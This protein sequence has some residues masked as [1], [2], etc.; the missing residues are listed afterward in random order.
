MRAVCWALGPLVAISLTGTA[1]AGAAEPVK[2]ADDDLQKQIVELKGENARLGVELRAARLEITVLRST[3]PESKLSHA[4]NLPSGSTSLLSLEDANTGQDKLDKLLTW[5]QNIWNDAPEYYD[6]KGW[7]LHKVQEREDS[8]RALRNAYIE[9]QAPYNDINTV[10]TSRGPGSIP[11]DFM[12]N[13]ALD[14]RIES[15]VDLD[16]NYVGACG[17]TAAMADL[18]AT[19]PHS[20]SESPTSGTGASYGARAIAPG[21]PTT[22]QD[23]LE[24]LP[25]WQAKIVWQVVKEVLDPTELDETRHSMIPS[26]ESNARRDQDY[27]RW[28]LGKLEAL[29]PKESLSDLVRRGGAPPDMKPGNHAE[30][31]R[32]IDLPSS[33]SELEFRDHYYTK[34]Q[35]SE[36]DKIYRVIKED[37]LAAQRIMGLPE[38]SK[39]YFELTRPEPLPAVNDEPLREK[40]G[41]AG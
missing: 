25:P 10:A 14:R 9:L 21:P 26:R 40:A 32:P 13:Q 24:A 33:N 37:F 30:I 34:S 5:L 1:V 4:S 6:P 29:L 36:T 3:Q 27:A 15:M 23:L 8:K 12:Q 7:L 35:I 22:A 41:R 17:G 20:L 19:P 18:L 28:K 2:D 38:A 11:L 39:R 16:G 31:G